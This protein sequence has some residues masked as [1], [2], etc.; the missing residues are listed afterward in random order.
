MTG[1]RALQKLVR[2]VAVAAAVCLLSAG[3]AAAHPSPSSPPPDCSGETDAVLVDASSEPDLYAA[4]LLAGV[5]N[6]ECVVD[7]GDR[8][9]KELPAASRRQLSDI[10]SGWIVG[11]TAAVPPVKLTAGIRWRRIGGSDRWAT[12]ALIGR[13]AT[14]SYTPPTEQ[15][16]G[17]TQTQTGADDFKAHSALVA[18]SNGSVTVTTGGIN[19]GAGAGGCL[20][21]LGLFN[22]QVWDYHWTAW[23]RKTGSGWTEVPGTRQT[24]KLCG[25]DLREAASGEY[26]FVGDMTLAGVRGEYKSAN[27]VTK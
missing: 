21:G 15:A 2:V 10:S 7:A 5:K 26:R 9:A 20:S 8:K 27:T 19:L 17:G 16:G 14:G 23:Q 12:L 3:P 4:H 11:G 24:G 22:G 25:H 6:T 18:N 13:T 1:T